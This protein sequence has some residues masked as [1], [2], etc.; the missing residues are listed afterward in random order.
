MSGFY[1]FLV[2]GTLCL[3]VGIPCYSGDKS[4]KGISTPAPFTL[5]PSNVFL[6]IGGVAKTAVGE[7]PAAT[8]VHPR[9][10]GVDIYEAAAPAVVMVR[11]DSGSGTGFL[12]SED[13]WIVTNHHVVDGAVYDPK[14]KANT[15]N[16]LRGKLDE[17]GWMDSPYDAGNAVVWAFDEKRDLAL[18][19]LEPKSPAEKFPY[20]RLSTTLPR[21]GE[22][23]VAIGCPGIGR[24]WS[25][26]SG[27]VTGAGREIARQV[28]MRVGRSDADRKLIE[29]Q[30]L[31]SE[32][33][34]FQTNLDIHP[35]DSGGPLLNSDGEV[36]GVTVA[37]RD[38]GATSLSLHVHLEELKTF[39]DQKPKTAVMMAPSPLDTNGLSQY[40]Q[41]E[42]EDGVIDAVIGKAEDGP[43]LSVAIRLN[44]APKIEIN[45]LGDDASEDG[46]IPH[47]SMYAIPTVTVAYD[48]DT[49]GTFDLILRDEDSDGVFDTKYT[50]VGTSWNVSPFQGQAISEKLFDLVAAEK[51]FAGWVEGLRQIKDAWIA[52]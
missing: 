7:Q 44:L 48:S 43:I 20:V 51:D 1:R 4:L 5:R 12:I 24:M 39:L 19:K 23:C 33:K 2:I 6:R 38:A 28:A 3:T 49:N 22:G 45:K 36:I 37:Y 47:F 15:M 9:G 10:I 29:Q 25:V 26:R 35:G 42:N 34:M 31:D 52:D 18:L 13:G 21:P 50:L 46:W 16:I 17:E 27:D 40:G 8:N 14:R 41:D 32:A 11:N 30:M